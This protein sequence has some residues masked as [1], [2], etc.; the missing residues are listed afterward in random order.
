MMC[1][2]EERSCGLELDGVTPGQGAESNVLGAFSAID[3]DA[4]PTYD[5]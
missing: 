4:I 5:F 2:V 3:P 1:Y